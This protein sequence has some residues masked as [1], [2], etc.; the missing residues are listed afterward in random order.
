MTAPEE[1]K[2][3]PFDNSW[4]ERLKTYSQT[5][6]FK[7]IYD[8]MLNEIPLPERKL[9]VPL[10][11]TLVGIPGSG[12]STLSTILQERIPAVHL[13]SDRIGL[14][15][16]PQGLDYD[17]YKSYVIQ[18][19]LA[20]H[21]LFRG[22]SVIMDDNNRTRVNRER[23]YAMAQEYG[24]ANIVFALHIPVDEAVRRAIPRDRADGRESKFVITPETLARYQAGTQFPTLDEVQQWD[25]LYRDIDSLTPLDEIR[26][27]IHSDLE[28]PAPAS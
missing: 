18:H 23:V 19:A 9:P 26:S 1:V 7:S 25:L 21:F 2:P 27:S 8:E 16:L 17:Y 13:R 22:Y 4:E 24:A 6:E 20:R 12:K 15:K 28:I 11:V 10:V 3:F 5:E 14:F